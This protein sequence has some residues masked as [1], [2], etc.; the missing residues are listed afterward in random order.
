MDLTVLETQ[1]ALMIKWFEGYPNLN[2]NEGSIFLNII[3]IVK[4]DMTLYYNMNEILDKGRGKYEYKDEKVSIVFSH[5]E[6]D[7]KYTLESSLGSITL[8]YKSF[9]TII[10]K[11]VDIYSE[12]YPLGT[13]VDINTNYLKHIIPV[14]DNGSIKVVIL[15]RF[16]LLT[17]DVFFYYTGVIYP[18]GNMGTDV[19][20]IYF[21]PI[22]INKVVHMGY[23][24]EKDTEY[25]L[26]KKKELL[27]D[28]GLHATSILT[29][30]EEKLIYNQAREL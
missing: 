15:N 26:N 8:D 3:D 6:N 25:V 11:I 1:K 12:I 7:E 23:T 10:S 27:V 28:K 9:K 14:E 5:C 22:A 13:V 18:I 20:M 17:E 30:D 16:T 4:N 19:G 21:S 2:S 24:D 29:E